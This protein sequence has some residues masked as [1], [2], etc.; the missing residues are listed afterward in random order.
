MITNGSEAF[1]PF[2]KLMQLWMPFSAPE[3][4]SQ[5]ILPGWSLIS[6]NESNSSAPDTEQ[7]IVAKSSYGKQLG[8]LVDAVEALI[9][10]RPASAPRLAAFDALHQIAA[11]IDAAKLAATSARLDRVRADLDLLRTHDP[12]AFAEQT[13]ALRAILAPSP[14]N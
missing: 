8:R 1:A 2:L 4:L 10:E 5:S 6:V 3:H 14:P 12:V 13:A 7:A 9:R 11:E